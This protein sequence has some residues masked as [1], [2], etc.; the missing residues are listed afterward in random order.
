MAELLLDPDIRI[1]VILPIV[2]ITLLVGVLRHYVIMLLHREK[3]L[4]LEALRDGQD[5][6]VIARSNSNYPLKFLV[7]H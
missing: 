2:I 3:R 1:W 4:T 6:D 5:F 7:R